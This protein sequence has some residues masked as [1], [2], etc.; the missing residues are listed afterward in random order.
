[1]VKMLLRTLMACGPRCFRWRY[2]IPSGPVKREFLMFMMDL[3][4]M[5]GVK[6]L[7]FLS[8]V[9]V[10]CLCRMCLSWSLYG[11]LLILE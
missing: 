7:M 10:S 3:A 2:D 5:S 9:I 11:S 4:V 6:K 8:R 1:M